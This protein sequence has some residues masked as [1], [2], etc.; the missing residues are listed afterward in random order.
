MSI[1]KNGN[2]KSQI[3]LYCNP[4]LYKDFKEA[5]KQYNRSEN[6]DNSISEIIREL[7]KG[8]ITNPNK[9]FLKNIITANISREVKDRTNNINIGGANDGV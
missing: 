1:N 2:E 5:V 9:E 7:M 8:F 6:T 4:K 3:H